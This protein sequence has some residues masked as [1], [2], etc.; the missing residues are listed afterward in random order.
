[1]AVVDLKQYIFKNHKIEFVLEKLNCHNIR[2]ND[3][4]E[5]YSASFPDGDNP[6]GI[7]IRNNEY[8]NYRSFS[9]NV[10]YEDC[11]D[12]ISLV[13]YIKKCNFVD[14]V[15]Y[16]HEILGIEYTPYKKQEKKEK[17]NPLDIFEKIKKGRRK[18]DVADIHFMQEETL[19]EYVPLLHISWFKEGIMPWTAKKFGLAYSYRRKRVIIP[20]RHWITGKL[21]GINARTT[22]ENWKELGIKKYFIT[23]TYQKGLNIFGLYENYDFIQKA[24]YVVVYESEKSVLKRDSLNDSTG[25]A[26]SGHTLSSEQASILIG[27]N[28]EIIIALD[29]DIN[30]AEVRH[31]CEKFYRIRPVSYI[32]DKW[33]LIGANDSPADAR[34]RIFNHLLKWR[35]KYDE[36]EHKRYIDELKM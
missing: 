6:Q 30:V 4:R 24:G 34:N 21:L 25:V 8:L 11:K 13:E 3:R 16:L 31:M 15:K 23:P 18:T 29:K 28:V 32:Y 27:L 2:Y 35:V 9:R 17:R 10:S 26:L 33:D 20:M 7:N 12:I 1:M 19:D 5:Y 14:A 36:K 22:I